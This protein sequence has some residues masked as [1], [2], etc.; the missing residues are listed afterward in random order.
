MTT[1]AEP[2]PTDPAWHQAAERAMVRHVEGLVE[3]GTVKLPTT[4]GMRRVRETTPKIERS[5]R[6]AELKRAMA[7][8]GRPDFELQR[9]MPAGERLDVALTAKVWGLFRKNVGRLAVACVSPTADLLRGDAASPLS[10]AE[11]D[12]LVADLAPSGKVPATV[13]VVSTAGFAPDARSAASTSDGRTVI[14]AAPHAAGGWAVHADAASPGLAA[15]LNPEPDTERRRRVLDALDAF[16]VDLLTGG[17][18]AERIAAKTR[19]PGDLVERELK[20]HARATPGLSAREVDGRLVLYR[21]ATT[22]P[23]SDRVAGGVSSQGVMTM[24]IGDAVRQIFSMKARPERK[25]ALLSERR[26]AL[27][28][29]RESAYDDLAALE[30]R[31]AE[32]RGQFA[33]APGELA[34]RRVTGQLLA[35]RKDVGRRQQVVA[36]LDQQMN[37]VATH[38]HHLELVRQGTPT[39]LPGSDDLAADAA[40]AEEVLASLQADSEMADALSGVSAGGVSDEEAALYDELQAEASAATPPESTARPASRESESPR[41]AAPERR[42][43]EPLT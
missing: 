40:E 6:S 38:L 37:V 7:D 16:R 10:R 33:A 39:K 30:G 23:A 9:R 21:D 18:S 20:A 31:E 5:D 11:V 36:V 2:I 8:A 32:L 25:I 13:V 35:L 1:D 27:S 12:R 42:R 4:G 41:L 3:A 43:A 24:P 19:L 28:T 15:A 14:L 26:A 29:Q 17:V 22:A 34:K